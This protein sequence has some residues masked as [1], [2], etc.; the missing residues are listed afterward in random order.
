MSTGEQEEL[1]KAVFRSTVNAI[2]AIHDQ[3]A[4]CDDFDPKLVRE[5]DGSELIVCSNCADDEDS[6]FTEQPILWIDGRV[7]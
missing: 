6:Q 7:V 2:E 1:R 3:S 4:Y 5:D